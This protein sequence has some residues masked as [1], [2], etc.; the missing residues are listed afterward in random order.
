VKLAFLL[1]LAAFAFA[2]ENDDLAR[3]LEQWQQD[4]QK[5]LRQIQDHTKDLDGSRIGEARA[6]AM[7]LAAV[8]H[9]LQSVTE[10]WNHP[11]RNTLLLSEGIFLVIMLFVK[12][13]RQ[14]KARNW[15]TKLLMSMALSLFTWVVVVLVLPYLVLGE[16]FKVVVV[17]LWR[18]FT[19]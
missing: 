5:V 6:K 15:F 18:V 1:F 4:A 13:W 14:A 8:D 10:L 19:S 12:A 11:K 7:R 3:E 16:P 2:N 9:F 17:T